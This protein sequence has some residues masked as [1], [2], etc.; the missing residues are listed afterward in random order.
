MAFYMLRNLPERP[1]ARTLSASDDVL[2]AGEGLK[3][4]SLARVIPAMALVAALSA[5]HL[6]VFTWPPSLRRL[7]IARDQDGA[8]DARSN[9][10]LPRTSGAGSSR[11]ASRRRG[12]IST[13]TCATSA[14]IIRAV[15][16]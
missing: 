7:Y 3:T 11:L 10:C 9:A 13:T 2:I 12:T 16:S 14:P 8:G 1:D 5:G 4:V 15:F 6:G